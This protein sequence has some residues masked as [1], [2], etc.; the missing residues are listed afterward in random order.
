MKDEVKVVL[1]GAGSLTFTPSLLKGLILS[2]I[3]KES[4]LTIALW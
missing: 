3:A 1:I 2:D 4:A